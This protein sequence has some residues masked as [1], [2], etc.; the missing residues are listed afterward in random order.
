MQKQSASANCLWAIVASSFLAALAQTQRP[1]RLQSA[2]LSAVSSGKPRLAYVSLQYGLGL[3]PT[4]VVLEVRD[5]AERGGCVTIAGEQ[6][7]VE[8]PVSEDLD[9]QVLITAITTYRFC[10]VPLTFVN[11]FA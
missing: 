8:I 3:L 1:A 5:S 10:G 9:Q 7:F 11:R 2:Q 4:S 6:L